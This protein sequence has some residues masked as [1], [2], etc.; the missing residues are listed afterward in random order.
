[1]A[2]FNYRNLDPTE[3]EALALDVMQRLLG[4]RLFRYAQGK[5][6][7]IDLCDNISEKRIVVQCKKYQQGSYSN[8]LSVLKNDEKPK[9]AKMNP[10]PEKYYVFTSL[11]LLQQQKKEIL[12]LFQ[13]YMEDES[14]IVDGI[15]IN[16]FFR[17]EKNH[18]LI[19]KNIKLFVSFPENYDQNKYATKSARV[20]PKCLTTY[21]PLGPE[22]GLVGRDKIVDELR[23][24]LDEEGCI[25][26]VRGLGGIG[27]TAVMQKVCDKILTDGNE[28]NHV[29]WIKCGDSL[30][31]D[32]LALCDAFS[33][34][35]EAGR[36]QAFK[37]VIREIKGMA[38]RL[39]LFL[40]DL[41][42]NSV[43]KDLAT[44]NSLRP[45]IHVMITSRREIKGIPY[46]VLKELK[47]D[48]AVDMFY[49]YYERD[50]ERKSLSD[51]TGIID[52]K[53]VKCHTLLVEL[54]AK[55]AKQSF[56]TLGEFRKKLEK[57]GFLE[58]YKLK[59]DTN[60]DENITI[61][62]CVKRLY[63]IS[64][65]STGQKRILSLFTIFTPE[66]EIYG[67][68]VE[69]A[70]LDGNEVNGLV[71]RGWLTRGEEG[72]VIHQI[73]K[74]SLSRQVGVDIIL[75]KYGK[76][77]SKVADTDT[78]IPDELEYTKVQGRLVVAEDV[79]RSLEDRTSK[80]LGAGSG[81]V[82]DFEFLIDS[83][84]LLN[85]IGCVYRVQGDYEKALEYYK[86]ALIIKEQVLGIEHPSTATTYNN[87]AD[88]YAK[89]GDCG[90][91]LKCLEIA[92]TIYEKT[93]GSE[94]L[95][96]AK[97]IN[98][99]GGVYCLLG[100]YA[101]AL[102]YYKRAI[103]IIE[104][105]LGGEH[106]FTATMLNNMANAYN[107]L[108]EYESALYYYEKALN[109]REKVLGTEHTDT[110]TTYNDLANI[111][112]IQKDYGKALDYYKKALSIYDRVLGS[113]HPHIGTMYNNM[114]WVYRSQGDY[115]KAL[116]LYKKALFIQ[117][118]KLGEDNPK[119]QDVLMSVMIM[120]ELIELGIN[121]E[122]FIEMIN[123]ME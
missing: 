22:I 35:Q 107:E 66:K 69:W 20:L 108:G 12:D 30:E 109:I 86:K 78:Y 2:Y 121:E 73:V 56:G 44:L 60:H 31:D 67:K 19:N 68:V 47:E 100:D 76:L 79:A 1:M 14:F 71:D 49:G 96:T 4:Y 120:E 34:S 53:S 83:S 10:R 81:S 101:K 32:I 59:L 40:D 102:Q 90:N 110:A 6:G 87:L 93:L 37:A 9:L 29:A 21:M 117:T 51:V 50:E 84:N 118:V 80:L 74:D 95:N 97:A 18:D 55:A 123:R 28:E 111:Y 113:E 119:V 54:L 82:K 61:E 42:R 63:D 36:E 3:F 98:N 13:V 16:D 7:G 85:N 11:E 77:L 38:G 88:A 94:H 58:V 25:A 75:E 23:R 48:S 62:E 105:L 39:Y 70:E 114:A 5:D 89:R 92:L 17:K 27:K 103:A 91:A 43:K 115:T 46:K 64:N 52:S 24:M 65:L 45:N 26:L 72:F 106:Q 33:I 112:R 99:I 8:L 104:K 15:A 57:E 122:Q 116:E 41:S